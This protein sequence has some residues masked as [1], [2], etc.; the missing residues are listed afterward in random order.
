MAPVERQ[1]K[2]IVYTYGDMGTRI[3]L[4]FEVMKPIIK[5]FNMN[6]L[7]ILFMWVIWRMPEQDMNWKLKQSGIY[8]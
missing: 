3:P 5:D 7:I 4:G 2:E 1:E 6:K 8:L